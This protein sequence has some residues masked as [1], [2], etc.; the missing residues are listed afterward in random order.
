MFQG[1]LTISEYLYRLRELKMM[2]DGNIS[3]IMGMSRK[4]CVYDFC[5]CGS[6]KK[7]KFCHWKTKLN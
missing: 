4:I 6:G 1:I 3:M 5:P 2:H 7:F